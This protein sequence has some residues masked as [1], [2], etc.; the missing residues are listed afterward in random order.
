MITL[1][2]D[3]KYI[4]NQFS[5]SSN[6]DPGEHHFIQI[7]ADISKNNVF[8]IGDNFVLLNQISHPNPIIYS[9]KSRIFCTLLLS[10]TNTGDTNNLGKFTFSQYKNDLDSSKEH[11]L[12][13]RIN[14]EYELFDKIYQ[15]SLSQISISFLMLELDSLDSSLSIDN[16]S[17]ILHWNIDPKDKYPELKIEGFSI[18]F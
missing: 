7:N 14:L 12:I 18:H 15:C 1:F 6:L 4:C 9:D 10:S 3:A 17:P 13:A 2:L 8:L 11:A 5:Q 16:D